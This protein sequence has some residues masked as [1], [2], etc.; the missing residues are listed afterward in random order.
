[1]GSLRNR[2]MVMMKADVKFQSRSCCTE[3]VDA[4]FALWKEK[5]DISEDKSV[6]LGFTTDGRTGSRGCFKGKINYL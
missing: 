2:R 1:M 3:R 4:R 5:G 6:S